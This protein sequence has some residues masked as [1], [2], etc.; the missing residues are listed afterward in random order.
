VPCETCGGKR[1]NRETLDIRYKGLTISEVLDLPIGEALALFGR[2]R[3]LARILQVL[4]DVGLDYV[5]LGQPSTTL[6]GGEAQRVKLASELHRPATGRTLY[7]LDE[8][9]TGLHFHDVSK[10]LIALQRLVDQGNTVI[11]VEHHTDVM[12]A[13][14]HLIDLGPEGGDGGGSV[15]AEGTPEALARCDTPTG[16]ALAA[17]ASR[18]A[19][20][21]VAE[22]PAPAVA[23]SVPAAIVLQGARKH[24]LQD[25][26][27]RIP[28]GLLTVVTGP[29]GSGK[30]SLAF[31]TVFA[32]G[33][34]RYVESLST[35]ARRFLGR[36]ERAPLTRA[37]GL[38]P[39]IAIDQSA[40]RHNPRSTVATV[41]EI[42]DM[43]RLLY[44]RVGTPHC[45][46]CPP[47]RET[48]L[49]ASSPSS[50]AR[51]LAEV[52]EAGWIVATLAPDP[53]PEERAALLARDGWTR[54][55]VDGAEVGLDDAAATGPLRTGATLVLDRVKPSSAAPSRLSE[56]VAHAY[57]LGEGQVAFLPRSGGPARRF[58]EGLVCP[59]HG[60][61]LPEITP[62]HFSFNARIGMCEHC[63]GL[64]VVSRAVPEDVIRGGGPLSSALSPPAAAL[65]G[66]SAVARQ[67]LHAVLAREGHTPETPVSAWSPTT[68]ARVLQGSS[69][70]VE[71]TRR[72]GRKVVQDVV[73][74]PGLVGLL[75]ASGEGVSWTRVDVP[76]PACGGGRLRP[77]V[78]AVTLGGQSIHAFSSLTVGDA[79]EVATSW[80]LEGAAAAIA[81]RARDELLRRLR[82]LLDV[83]LGYLTLDREASTL[84]GGEAQRIRLA[85]QLGAGLTGVT[86]VLDEPTVGLHPRDT[87]RLLGT[88]E[89]LRDAGNTVLVV[90]HDPDTIR[91]ADHVI[92]MGPGAGRHGGRVIAAGTPAEIAADP[93]APTGRWLAGLD[94]MPAFGAR[95]EGTGRI[96]LVGPRANNLQ[97]P[98]VSVPTGAWTAVTG[99]S[100]SGKSSLI[101]DTLAPALQA[102]AGQSATGARFDDLVV[103]VPYDGVV[104][105][106][107]LPLGRTPRSTPATYLGIMDRLRVLFSETAGARARGWGPGRFTFNTPGGRCEACEG[108]GAQL[109]EMHFLPDVWVICDSCRGRRF[110]RETLEVRWRG[111]NLAEVLALRADEAV[112][113]FS[114]HRALRGR[115][116]ALVDVGLGY[117]TLGQPA[118]TL[119]GGEAQ[120]VKLAAELVSRAGHRIYVLDEPTTGLHLGDV[121]KLV[122]V[123]RRLVEQGHTVL[124]I[125]HHLDMIAAADHVVELGPEGGAAGG[126]LIAQGTPE[127]VAAADTPTGRALAPHLAASAEGAA[128]PAPARRRTGRPKATG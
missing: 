103:D 29:S 124:T 51:Q 112:E 102:R 85:S 26:D 71:V 2:H 46:H 16:R 47:A 88:L 86:Y 11:V 41:T 105:V 110:S 96:T 52:D 15:V 80:P 10:L 53:A 3:K 78:L 35:Y 82:F 13:A 74:W 50:V 38:Q 81:E 7:L 62:R 106:D 91:R 6:S 126:R 43:L 40:S 127:Q 109:V 19:P 113:T 44:A 57:R 48:V 100:G 98:S 22:P 69:E 21:L 116:Q 87:E 8:P 121:R 55:L 9:T 23:R 28:H 90:E 24:N 118:T 76:C 4:V 32:E 97:V 104:V 60:P 20:D 49:T 42:H 114:A 18:A 39:A 108:R 119:S 33:Q 34:R 111:L 125:E 128:A 92:D 66:R 73:T 56:A 75:A 12:R 17:E 115:L 101:M 25:I 59:F 83:G 63:E 65:L 64:G 89:G 36:L 122:E 54:L 94:R 84:S 45:P 120:R 68:W 99:V 37:E 79:L 5:T 1:F 72:Q 95:R 117:M 107:Q 77:E 14:D 123:L 70:P 61:V 67:A 30:T 58:T 93:Q 31:D 27:V